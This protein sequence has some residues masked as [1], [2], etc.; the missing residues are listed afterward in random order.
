[1]KLVHYLSGLLILLMGCLPTDR[2]AH[3]WPNGEGA[4]TYASVESIGFGRLQCDIIIN[5]QTTDQELEDA[6]SWCRYR[7]L[8]WL[9]EHR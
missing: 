3:A 1:M 2:Q 4:S 5:G 8:N 9:G 7:Q 6:I